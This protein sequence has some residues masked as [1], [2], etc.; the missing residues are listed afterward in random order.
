MTKREGFG[1]QPNNPENLEN[2]TKR[3]SG[4]LGSYHRA[5][6]KLKAIQRRYPV[7]G[8][9]EVTA[10]ITE[11][12]KDRHETHLKLLELGGKLD[13]DKGDVL[14]DIIR[15]QR[16]L[17]EYG[18]P[19]FSMLKEDDIVE[20]GD[21]HN[22]YYF[23]VDKD[24]RLPSEGDQISWAR[25]EGKSAISKDKFMLVFAIV[26][27][28][29]Y[30]E[31]VLEPD[32]YQVRVK[33]AEALAQQLGGKIFEEKD[34]SYH[35]GSAKILGVVFPKRDLEKIVG[36]IRNSPEKFRLGKEYYSKDEMALIK[37]IK[38]EE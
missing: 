1:E 6:Q 5:S 17:E 10:K 22:P 33:R 32:D 8:D 3:Y 34:S 15:Q 27:I 36:T 12:D 29:N 4:L 2:I 31:D 20:T 13:K 35:E 9:P 19:E 11:L 25:N 24:A 28:E 14:V 23:N 38:G 7:P 21:W 30:G 18:L 26:P 16:T 37:K